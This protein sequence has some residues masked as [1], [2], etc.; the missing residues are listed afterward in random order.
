VKRKERKNKEAEV[1]D[2]EES[3]RGVINE[4]ADGTGSRDTRL[5]QNDI[6]KPQA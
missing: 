5:S 2:V 3:I 4:A 6:W 1:R